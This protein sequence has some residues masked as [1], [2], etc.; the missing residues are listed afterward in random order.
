MHSSWTLRNIL[1]ETIFFT[2]VNWSKKIFQTR[3]YFPY[4]PSFGISTLLSRRRL[5]GRIS[6]FVLSSISLFPH[7]SLSLFLFILFCFFHSFSFSFSFC[8][9]YIAYYCLNHLKTILFF[10]SV[11]W[12]TYYVILCFYYWKSTR[13]SWTVLFWIRVIAIVQWWLLYW[14]NEFTKWYKACKVKFDHV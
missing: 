14:G 1:A 12:S 7:S 9:I 10:Y 13:S 3:P 2:F 4:H 5:T 8:L 11:S 6:P